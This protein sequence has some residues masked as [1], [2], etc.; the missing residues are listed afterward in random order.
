MKNPDTHIMFIKIA[1]PHRF[2][3]Y[4]NKSSLKLMGISDDMA[5][6]QGYW[7]N[8]GN[9]PHR[10]ASTINKR[11]PQTPQSLLHERRKMKWCQNECKTDNRVSL[12]GAV[13][14]YRN[15]AELEIDKCR[16]WTDHPAQYGNH[17][18]CFSDFGQRSNLEAL[19]SGWGSEGKEPPLFTTDKSLW[20]CRWHMLSEC[21]C[22]ID[23][24]RGSV[25]L[26]DREVED[27]W[28]LL[29]TLHR[30]PAERRG[31][32]TEFELRILASFDWM[33]TWA[34]ETQQ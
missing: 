8:V 19:S 26:E 21:C 20:N 1:R 7:I 33:S 28:S 4:K 23:S 29:V 30:L 14:F 31:L 10:T 6:M 5:E 25:G 13:R 32:S 2:V 3:R 24:P 22:G 16:V 27:W 34:W 15:F 18:H 9:L 17:L 12:L 11:R